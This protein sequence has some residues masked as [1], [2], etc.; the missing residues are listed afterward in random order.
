[1]VRGSALGVLGA[2]AA[3]A[4]LSASSAPA[5][6]VRRCECVGLTAPSEAVRREAPFIFRGTVHE[7]IEITEHTTALRSTSAT[8][9][10]RYIDR[11]VVFKVQ[12]GWQGVTSVEVSVRVGFSDCMYPFQIDRQYLVFANRDQDGVA[13]TSRCSRTTAL[14]DAAGLLKFLGPPAYRGGG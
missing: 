10:S 4:A 1:M 9:S 12:A 13:T 5:H 3:A 6:S 8:S 14:E 7:I 11:R 2:L